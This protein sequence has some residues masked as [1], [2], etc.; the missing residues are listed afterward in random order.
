MFNTITQY[1]S[2]DRHYLQHGFVI[3]KIITCKIEHTFD[4]LTH[5]TLF[6][7]RLLKKKLVYDDEELRYPLFIF[8]GSF[9]HF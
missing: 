9:I 1:L 7:S 2:S 5:L 4:N 6:I 3:F 8:H